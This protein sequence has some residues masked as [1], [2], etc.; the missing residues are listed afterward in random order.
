MIDVL[1]STRNPKSRHLTD[2]AS[3]PLNRRIEI[4]TT[5]SAASSSLLSA[6]LEPLSSLSP[7]SVLLP[8]SLLLSEPWLLLQRRPGT[9]LLGLSSSPSPSSPRNV[10]ALLPR[11]RLRLT[12]DKETY[13]ELGLPAIR[14]SP[15]RK[16]DRWQLDLD[17]LTLGGA[18][19][20]RARWA[21]TRLA[22]VDMLLLAHDSEGLPIPLP[23]LP[24]SVPL[25][26]RPTFTELPALQP[27]PALLDAPHELADWVGALHLR[28]G[29]YLD[30]PLL[31]EGASFS[32]SWRPDPSYFGPVQ[33]T[34]LLHIE[35]LL[36]PILLSNLL[37]C[38]E[39]HV[40]AGRL[41]W[42]VFTVWGFDH[43]PVSWGTAVRTPLLPPPPH[44]LPPPPRNVLQEHPATSDGGEN[45][46]SILLLPG[47]GYR[48]IKVVG[49][50]DTT[51]C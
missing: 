42:V 34:T 31:D 6:A 36:P 50:H 7:Q 27:Q 12:M 41:P 51:S 3:H 21:L 33:D 44:A 2:V 1:S 48:M 38:L 17:L 19:L 25:L 22:P 49:G 43:T 15:P 37:R 23:S 39:D 18:A 47:G 40:E 13:Q 8:P 5:S 11:A 46:L 24:A 28:L 10:L 4:A 14:S 9:T 45:D 16:G 26:I 29:S 32:S 35:A 30:P 20:D